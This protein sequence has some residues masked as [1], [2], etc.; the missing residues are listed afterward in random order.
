MIGQRGEGYRITIGR[1]KHAD[2]VRIISIRVNRLCGCTRLVETDVGVEGEFGEFPAG[3]SDG[4]SVSTRCVDLACF[5]LVHNGA[6]VAKAI[7]LAGWGLI[8]IVACGH[9]HYGHSEG[10]R[11]GW[12][13]INVSDRLSC[14]STQQGQAAGEKAGGKGG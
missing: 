14:T 7:D 12:I 11:V 4:I 3:S 5:S 13:A 2:E 6:Q 9:P 1:G 8:G 10:A